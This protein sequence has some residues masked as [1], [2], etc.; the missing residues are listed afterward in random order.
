MIIS[1]EL[2]SDP[3]YK[4]FVFEMREGVW[5]YVKPASVWKDK[6]Y[7]ILRG[8]Y[9]IMRCTGRWCNVESTPKDVALEKKIKDRLIIE[10]TDNP[11]EIEAFLNS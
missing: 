8:P 4:H 7:Y 1:V 11:M 2:P 3:A 6:A 9:V 5:R 10:F